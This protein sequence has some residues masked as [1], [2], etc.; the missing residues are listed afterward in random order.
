MKLTWLGHACYQIENEQGNI[1]LIDPYDPQL[2]YPKIQAKA[3]IVTTS[4]GHYDHN[5][6]EDLPEGFVLLDDGQPYH[7]LGFD[8]YGVASF[9]DDAE[10][11][12]RGANWIYVIE[13]DGLRIV[14]LGDLGHALS[15]K[16]LTQLG[17][18]DILLLPIGGFY[19]IDANQAVDVMRAIRARV[20]IPMHYRNRWWTS[21]NILPIEAF[22][23]LVESKQLP[24]NGIT[25]THET[26]TDL[27]DVIVL[28]YQ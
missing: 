6:T 3:D 7:G 21:E 2:G 5:Y 1:L 28:E 14:H 12:K 19:T 26:I 27:P 24:T 10:G 11:A 4:H 18:V 8:V 15:A 17:R 20:T 9:H 22:T 23:S 16:Q 13:T 25:C